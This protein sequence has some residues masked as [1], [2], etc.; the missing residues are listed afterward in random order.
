MSYVDAHFDR[1][2]DTIFV[3]ERNNGIRE[4]REYP[5]QYTAYFD[6]PEVST[7]VLWYKSTRYERSADSKELKVIVPTH[8]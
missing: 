7:L 2:K 4:Y 8:V 5:V 1:Q 3:V 6:D